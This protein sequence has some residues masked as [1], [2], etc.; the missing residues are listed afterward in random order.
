MVGQLEITTKKKCYLQ[1]N[2]EFFQCENEENIKFIGYYF[3][4]NN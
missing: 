1:L 4:F 2:N 3:Q